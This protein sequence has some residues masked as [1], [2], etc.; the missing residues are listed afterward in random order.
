VF[1]LASLLAPLL[2]RV[3]IDPKWSM[4]VAALFGY[5]FWVGSMLT[6]VAWVIY[7]SSALLG[8]AAGVLW[9]SEGLYV[10]R[11]RCGERGHNLFLLIYGFAVLLSNLISGLVLRYLSPSTFIAIFCGIC[12]TGAM[13]IVF[14][15]SAS[16][17]LPEE[18]LQK[19]SLRTVFFSLRILVEWRM[20]LLLPTMWARSC[21]SAFLVSVLP[22]MLPSVEVVPWV[23]LTA[24]IVS[25]ISGFAVLFFALRVPVYFWSALHSGP[26]AIGMILAGCSL[27]VVGDGRLYMLYVVGGLLGVNDGVGQ[28]SG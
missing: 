2:S 13:M 10:S 17:Q 11:S 21:T 26:I 5:C 16:A 14:S 28:V 18:R 19:V 23:L 24:G 25:L 22:T 20:Y 7:I 1:A 12:G 27:L 6:G 15:P 3:S 9:V 4:W 8:I